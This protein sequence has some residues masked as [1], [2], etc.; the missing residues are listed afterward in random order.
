MTRIKRWWQ[1]EPAMT[2][3]ILGI[4]VAIFLVEWL[5][6]DQG[7]LLFNAIGAKNNQAIAAG[8]WWRFITPIFLH[9][10]LTHIALNSVVI[11]FM[12]MQIEAM[13]GH[14]RFLTVYLLGGISGNIMSFALSSNHQLGQV[15]HVSPY[16]GLS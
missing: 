6:G 3:V 10:G 11:Y 5:L 16:L 2:Q 13:Y 8:Q 4:T 15:R 7:T 14:W 1:T 9:M 12:G